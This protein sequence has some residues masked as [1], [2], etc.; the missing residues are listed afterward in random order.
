V[1]GVQTCALPIC[2]RTKKIYL[3]QYYLGSFIPCCFR[4]NGFII[5]TLALADEY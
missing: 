2:R 3:D 5:Y 4:V 1:T